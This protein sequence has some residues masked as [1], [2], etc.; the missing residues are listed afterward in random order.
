MNQPHFL[1]YDARADKESFDA[2]ARLFAE[3]LGK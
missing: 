1:K 3:V 2:M